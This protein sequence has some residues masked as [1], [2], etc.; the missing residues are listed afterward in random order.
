MVRKFAGMRRPWLIQQ[1]MLLIAEFGKTV[2]SDEYGRWMGSV[3]TLAR[4]HNLI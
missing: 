2:T 1:F 4:G 3:P